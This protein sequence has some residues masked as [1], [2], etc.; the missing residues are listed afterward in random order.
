MNFKNPFILAKKAAEEA[1]E[2]FFEEFNKINKFLFKSCL[3]V[4]G[5]ILEVWDNKIGPR[6]LKV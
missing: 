1:E 6:I 2:L 5:L 3:Y 4:D